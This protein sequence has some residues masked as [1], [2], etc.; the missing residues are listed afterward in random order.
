MNERN[1]DLMYRCM[2]II[3]F[4]A[5]SIAIAMTIRLILESLLEIDNKTLQD[6]IIGLALA[7]VSAWYIPNKIYKK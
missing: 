6:L 4:L 7:S 3:I 1:L 2:T 5:G